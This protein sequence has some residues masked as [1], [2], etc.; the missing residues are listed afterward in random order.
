MKQLFSSEQEGHLAHKNPMRLNQNKW[1]K[2][3][4]K[5]LVNQVDLENGH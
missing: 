3:T 5:E 1:K 4:K 2:T